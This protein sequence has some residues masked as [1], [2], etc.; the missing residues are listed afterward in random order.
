[1]KCDR[2]KAFMVDKIDGAL[3]EGDRTSLENHLKEC[4]W[5]ADAS[6]ELAGATELLTQLK[7]ESR[8]ISAPFGFEQRLKTAIEGTKKPE[9]TGWRLPVFA[10]AAAMLVVALMLFHFSPK[11]LVPDGEFQFKGIYSLVM[12][13]SPFGTIDVLSEP[14]LYSITFSKSETEEIEIYFNGDSEEQ[15]IEIEDPAPSSQESS[16]T[17]RVFGSR[18]G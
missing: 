16:L 5:C 6:N 13:E 10:A 2:A 9:R 8:K 17:K 12:D 15:I 3:P 11:T 14:A 18:S 7:N 1:M 4:R